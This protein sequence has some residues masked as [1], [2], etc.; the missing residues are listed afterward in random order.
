MQNGMGQNATPQQP[1]QKQPNVT[2]EQTR[3]R[4]QP[5]NNRAQPT[6][7]S[8]AAAA[9]NLK[10]PSSDDNI[11]VPE[12]AKPA[13]TTNATQQAQPQQVRGPLNPQQIATLSP[14]QRAKYEQMMKAQMNKA[15][16]MQLQAG[17]T[18]PQA[19]QMQPQ[20][21]NEIMARLKALGQEEQRQSMLENM[22]EI[23]MSP[24]EHGETASKLQRIVVDMSKIG[25][26][27][28]KWYGL[29]HDDKRAKLFFRT[30]SFYI[31]IS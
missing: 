27:L 20:T 31:Q 24:Q 23:S 14:E 21:Q 16:Q 15:G 8:P 13:P 11:D 19:G 29:T 17:Q 26:G 9:K 6:N 18:Q 4:P 2:P 7:P 22:P 12:S 30:V 10:R 1:G 28:S 3:A 25:R 5:T